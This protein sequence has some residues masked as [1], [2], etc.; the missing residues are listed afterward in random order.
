MDHILPERVYLLSLSTILSAH[1]NFAF[2]LSSTYFFSVSADLFKFIRGIS[3]TLVLS[4][5][6]IVMLLCHSNFLTPSVGFWICLVNWDGLFWNYFIND[7]VQHHNEMRIVLCLGRLPIRDFFNDPSALCL[8]DLVPGPYIWAATWQ[9]NKLTVCPAK[10]GIRPVWSE[11]SLCAQWIAKGPIFLHADSED[12]DQ[13]GR[14][15][16][17]IWVFAMHTVTLL[18]LLCRGLFIVVLYAFDLSTWN[19][20]VLQCDLTYHVHGYEWHIYL[21]YA[22]FL[23]ILVHY[24]CLFLVDWPSFYTNRLQRDVISTQISL[25][26]VSDW[27]FHSWFLALLLAVPMRCFCCRLF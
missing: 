25:F 13:T 18:I 15:P 12:S 26:V 23:L 1:S 22:P 5:P 27:Q 19:Q 8:S 10:T 9:N 2:S 21:V 11:S 16:R 7:F 4:L 20:A 6:E 24:S 17:L 3:F 14:M